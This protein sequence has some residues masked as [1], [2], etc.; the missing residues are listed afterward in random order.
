MYDVIKKIDL[1]TKRFICKYFL[2]FIILLKFASLQQLNV[3]TLIICKW[4]FKNLV[5]NISI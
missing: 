1:V 4:L 5:K 3:K 2:K